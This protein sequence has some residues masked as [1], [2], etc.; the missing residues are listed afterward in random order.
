MGLR[1]RTPVDSTV[2]SIAS[3]SL[4]A[5]VF[6]EVASLLVDINAAKVQSLA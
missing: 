2:L 3:I 5:C 6:S 4:F 1:E